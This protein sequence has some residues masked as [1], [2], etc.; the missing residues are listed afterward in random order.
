MVE[1]REP[2]SNGREACRTLELVEAIRRP[3]LEG[4]LVRL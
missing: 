3:A 1:G 4:C 2:P